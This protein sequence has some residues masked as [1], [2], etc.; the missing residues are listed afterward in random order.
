[1][2]ATTAQGAD[3]PHEQ[4]VGERPWQSGATHPVA[5]RPQ[6][7]GPPAEAGAETEDDAELRAQAAALPALMRPRLTRQAYHEALEEAWKVIRAANAYIDRQAPW[8]L[9]KTDPPAW[10]PCCAFWRT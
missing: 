9:R 3:Q 10:P 1:M 5:D 8:V 7:R 6:L 4:R 2:T